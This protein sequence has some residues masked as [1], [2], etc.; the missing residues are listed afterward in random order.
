MQYCMTHDSGFPNYRIM[1][2]YYAVFLINYASKR[3]Q[4]CLLP[5][6][7]TQFSLKMQ[8]KTKEQNLTSYQELYC[9]IIEVSTIIPK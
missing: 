7:L 5:I 3:Y 9:N 1:L 2:F 4:L 6:I 8:C